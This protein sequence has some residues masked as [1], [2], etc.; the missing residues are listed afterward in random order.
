[1]T[2]PQFEQPL[3]WRKLRQF[4]PVIPLLG[5]L[6]A[7][8]FS[9]LDVMGHM[10]WSQDAC[11]M[12]DMEQSSFSAKMYLPLANWALRYTPTPS[13]A[14]LLIDSNTKPTSLLTNTCESRA[15]L[16]KLVQN[17]NALGAHAIVIDQYFSADYCT[18]SDKN[19]RFIAAIEGSSVPIVVGQPT[20]AMADPIAAG[21]LAL[22]KHL[23]FKPT[24][25]VHYG[26]TRINSDDLKIPLRW[27]VFAESPDHPLGGTA[28][29]PATQQLPASAG[30]T[31]SLVAARMQ[32]PNIESNAGV[33]KLLAKGRHPYTTFVDLPQINA[34]TVMCSAEKNPVDIFGA[35]LGEACASWVKP[36]SNLDGHNLSLG[37]KVVV[38][39]ALSPQDMKPFPTGDK[40]GVYMQANYVQSIL[41]HRFLME[42]PP[43][44][45]LGCLIV[46]VFVI[47]S[48][49][50]AHDSEG[51][52]L[53]SIGQAGLLSLA[54]LVCV[55]LLSIVVLITTSYFTPLWAIWGVA[56]FMV[57]RYLEELGHSHGEHLLGKLTHGD[58]NTRSVAETAAVPG[59]R[60]Q[61]GLDED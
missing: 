23:E 34:M 50:W 2:G 26:L 6:F 24:A 3:V 1:M 5:I 37:G 15:F 59:N 39:G 45:T 17:L 16:A 12:K 19:A 14:I 44:L 48:L 11:A 18:E 9:D 28:S 40:P 21:C 51:E 29:A 22:T 46:V 7:L 41:D 56:V 8:M 61:V 58:L 33:A 42:I 38:V 25:N 60:N 4:W 10:P 53:L 27:P 31:L 57:F 49:Y 35:K 13:V 32:D 52:A 30:D 47:Y 43:T 20:H 55:V 54:I 36:L